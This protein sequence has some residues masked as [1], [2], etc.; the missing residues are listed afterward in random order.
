MKLRFLFPVL[1]LAGC[2]TTAQTVATDVQVVDR[3]VPVPC[4]IKLPEKP[5]PYVSQVQLTGTTQDLV[6]IWRAAEAELESRIGYERE[7]EAAA[8]ACAG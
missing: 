7:L 1:F 3:P 8:R 2:G 5:V 6:L 4:K